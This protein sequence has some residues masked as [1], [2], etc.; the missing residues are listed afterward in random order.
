MVVKKV[1]VKDSI[2]KIKKSCFHLIMNFKWTEK[3]IMVHYD[4]LI[5]CNTMRQVS[6]PWWWSQSVTQ[7]K[8]KTRNYTH[9]RVH[10]HTPTSGYTRIFLSNSFIINARLKLAKIQ[11]NVKQNPKAEL[12]LFENYWRSLS[13]LSS[14]NNRT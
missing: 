2:L 9:N 4:T 11:A 3:R 10:T 1:F 7:E 5:S 12:L 8:E 14:E 6:S 13:T